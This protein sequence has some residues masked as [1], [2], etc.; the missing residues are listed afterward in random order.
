MFSFLAHLV[1]TKCATTFERDSRVNLCTRCGGPLFA[2][3]HVRPLDR[4]SGG[5]RARSMWRWHEMMPVEEPENVVTLGEG[6]TP[7]LRVE[8]LGALARFGDLWLKD[9][10]GNATG[11]FKA[12]GLSAAI[13]RAK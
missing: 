4:A 12:R 10:S 7:L 1:C 2:K 9:E 11:S 3:Y 8:R 6:G 5:A 13:S